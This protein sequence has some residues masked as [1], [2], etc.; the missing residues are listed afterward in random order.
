MQ[1]RSVRPQDIDFFCIIFWKP[2]V[3][4]SSLFQLW[5]HSILMVSPSYLIRQLKS[6]L[7][8]LLWCR[9]S[10][11]VGNK[12]KG[13]ISKRV[14]QERKARPIF[15][16]TNIFHPLVR[17]WCA[18]QG[19]R[20][21]RFSGNWTCFFTWSTRFEIRPFALLPANCLCLFRETWYCLYQR[22]VPLLLS[23]FILA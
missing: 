21:V 23:Q 16:K 9:R 4:S 1:A 7:M 17:T 14:F 2:I 13:R 20:N 22:K 8:K 11:F 6:H 15:R 19:V 18:Y 10:W 3:A 5:C 12:A